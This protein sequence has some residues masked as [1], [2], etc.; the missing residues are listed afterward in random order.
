MVSPLAQHRGLRIDMALVLVL[1]ATYEPISVVSQR[2]GMT[3]VLSEKADSLAESDDVWHSER[4]QFN[5]P[6]VVKLRYFVKVP[7]RRRAPLHRRALFARDAH[8]CQYCGDAAECVDHVHP[9]SKGGQHTWENVVACCKRCN[10]AKGDRLLADSP[11]FRLRRPP[12]APSPGLWV[13]LSVRS[14]PAAWVP[15]LPELPEGIELA[16][17]A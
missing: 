2:R 9:R 5:P 12:T 3:L 10:L 16:A 11:Q 1:N 4:S 13:A 15:Y 7:R 17:T 6:E 8:T 14:L